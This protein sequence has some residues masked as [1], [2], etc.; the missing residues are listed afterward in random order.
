MLDR[1][2]PTSEPDGALES[3]MDIN[4]ENYGRADKN[5]VEKPISCDQVTWLLDVFDRYLPRDNF[6]AVSRDR[7]MKKYAML[8][9]I[10]G[11]A[12]LAFED[13]CARWNGTPNDARD[14]DNESVIKEDF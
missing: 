5:T 9:E 8:Y 6:P 13:S 3:D 12:E 14:Y 7:E 4:V 11:I 2:A 10:V 1:K